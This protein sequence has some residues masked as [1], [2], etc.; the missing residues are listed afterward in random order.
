MLFLGTAQGMSID[1]RIVPGYQAAAGNLAKQLPLV[2]KEFKPVQGCHPGSI[3]VL[4]TCP[5]RIVDPDFT[6]TSIQ[7]DQNQYEK[8]NLTEVEFECP[9]GGWHYKAWIYDPQHSPHRFN[10]YITEVI[11]RP[12]TG[13][14][15][16]VQCRIHLL[17]CKGLYG[18]VIV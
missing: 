1:G 4:L 8:F 18:M 15:Y 2:Q 14:S 7:W 5:L 9:I 12:I 16:G 6:T 11:S 17:R 10:D 3:N 13:A